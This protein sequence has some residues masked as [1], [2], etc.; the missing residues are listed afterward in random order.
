MALNA[1]FEGARNRGSGNWSI[2]RSGRSVRLAK[3]Q[4]Q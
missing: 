4:A 3:S 2:D 1:S